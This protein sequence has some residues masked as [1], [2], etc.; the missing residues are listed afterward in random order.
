MLRYRRKEVAILQ[1]KAVVSGVGSVLK[2]LSH[3]HKGLNA[4]PCKKLGTIA[5]AY[6]PCLRARRIPGCC[7]A[8]ISKIQVY[9]EI[10]LKKKKKESD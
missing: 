9:W 8:G 1:G 6:N 10:F 7:W 3:K 5:Q 4:C 2:F